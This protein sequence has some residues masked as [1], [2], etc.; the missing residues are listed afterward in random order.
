MFKK[1]DKPVSKYDRL[2][3]LGLKSAENMEDGSQEKLRAIEYVERLEKL[4]NDE[5][6][7][8]VDEKDKWIERLIKIG[9][10]LLEIGAPL[11]LYAVFLNRGFKFEETGTYTSTTFR[12][13]FGR[14]G[15]KK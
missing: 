15:P 6:R 5:K 13:L 10:G 3:E 8:N 12:N 11:T 14:F 1:K 9:L 4:K 2:I 7:S